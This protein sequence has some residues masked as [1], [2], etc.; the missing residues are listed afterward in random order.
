MLFDKYVNMLPQ[1]DTARKELGTEEVAEINT[2]MAAG[3]KPDVTV[4]IDAE[5]S[6]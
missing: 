5:V 4:T 1:A 2:L 3:A 6:P